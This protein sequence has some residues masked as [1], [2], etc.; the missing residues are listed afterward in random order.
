MLNSTTEQGEI[1]MTAIVSFLRYICLASGGIFAAVVF[2]ELAGAQIP[3]NVS[4]A[5]I[6]AALAISLLT[7]PMLFTFLI[8]PKKTIDHENDSQ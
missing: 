5:L 1:E 6:G 3:H 7:L 4:F 8:E 2:A